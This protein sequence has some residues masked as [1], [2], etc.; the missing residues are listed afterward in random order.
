MAMM[1]DGK[2]FAEDEMV[3][4]VG[5]TIT[6]EK[7]AGLWQTATENRKGLRRV[8][9][10]AS[11]ARGARPP[12]LTDGAKGLHAAVR[13][14]FDR[15]PCAAMSM[16]QARERPGVSARATSRHAE[17]M[18]AGSGCGCRG[19]GPDG[20]RRSSL[21][22]RRP[23]SAGTVEASVCAGP[24]R[25]VDVPADSLTASIDAKARLI[26]LCPRSPRQT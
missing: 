12:S 9:A 25:A 8:S 1:L 4:A 16:A 10:H 24:G 22:N 17:D 3:S 18:T 11:R 26:G 19:S 7:V 6:G 13:E 5:V 2:T 21:L 15:T 23:S 14:V 20:E